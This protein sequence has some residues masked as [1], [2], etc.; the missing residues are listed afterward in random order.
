MIGETPLVDGR[1]VKDMLYEQL[2]RV[3]KAMAS[4]KRIELVELLC[5]GERTVEGLSRA[6]GMP[7]TTT[8]A[9]LQA[10]R[11]AGLVESRREGTKA[12]YRVADDEV[13]RLLG[14]VRALAAS[15]LVEIER[16]VRDHFDVLDGLE[17]VDREGLLAMLGR[18]DI[19]VID[20]RPQEEYE[21]GHIRG[22]ISVPL[23][24]LRGWLADL[25]TRTEVVA[26][27]RGPYCVLAPQA[28]HMLRAKG[29]RARRLEEGFPEW[30]LAGLPVVSGGS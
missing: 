3:G 11:S 9:H 2:A 5:Q 27:C 13:C 23:P 10:L 28:L 24:D 12:F 6:A 16:I 17:P 1:E 30:R 29:F 20:V 4:P 14:Q 26:Y 25:P 8:S 19:V 7:V 21:A 22:A 15:R 18:D